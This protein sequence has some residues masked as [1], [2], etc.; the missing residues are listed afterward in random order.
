ME[1]RTTFT[2]IPVTNDQGT[3]KYFDF[4]VGQEEGQNEYA[5]ITMDGCQLILD[6]QLAYLSGDLPE[7]WHRPAID[8]LLFLLSVDRNTDN[9]AE[10]E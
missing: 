9:S 2:G 1:E 5:R 7:E 10:A 8:K 4:E 6:E 3:E